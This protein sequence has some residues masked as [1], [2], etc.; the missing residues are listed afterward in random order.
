MSKDNSC[1]IL[2]ILWS[3]NRSKCFIKYHNTFAKDYKLQSRKPLLH[4]NFLYINRYNFLVVSLFPIIFL[5]ISFSCFGC[6]FNMKLRSIQSAQATNVEYLLSVYCEGH[7]FHTPLLQ[8]LQSWYSFF[9]FFF[10]FL[11]VICIRNL[12]I[13]I[14]ATE[15][16]KHYRYIMLWRNIQPVERMTSSIMTD[17]WVVT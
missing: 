3:S 2:S 7:I 12:N 6:C 10:Y 8:A 11:L 9:F 15:V 16:L 5:A 4:D 13:F 14:S 1:F 17:T